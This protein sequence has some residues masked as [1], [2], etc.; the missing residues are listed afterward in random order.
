MIRLKRAHEPPDPSDG[1][2]ILV[3][4]SWPRGVKKEKLQATFWMKEAAPGPELLKWF[5]H[6][7]AKWKEFR[8]RYLKELEEPRSRKALHDI[9]AAARK[10]TITLVHGAKD[11]DHTPALVL[12]EAIEAL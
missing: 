12:K 8:E 2:R 11:A 3:D 4:R 10:G 1:V 5:D 6:D 9:A 7:P